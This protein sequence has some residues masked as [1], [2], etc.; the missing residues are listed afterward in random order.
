MDSCIAKKPSV[1]VIYQVEMCRVA[2]KILRAFPT[3]SAKIR[4]V[5]SLE[6]GQYDPSMTE[7]DMPT[8]RTY[9]A[10]ISVQ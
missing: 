1:F 8:A 4:G 3:R 10:L 9:R 7:A 2:I 5:L 6:V